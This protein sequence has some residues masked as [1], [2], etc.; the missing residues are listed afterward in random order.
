[1]VKKL[2]KHA[3]DVIVMRR[4]RVSNKI[5]KIVWNLEKSKLFNIAPLRFGSMERYYDIMMQHC[6]Y[7]IAIT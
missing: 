4:C 5:S 3:R 2:N 1:M 7:N 6:E